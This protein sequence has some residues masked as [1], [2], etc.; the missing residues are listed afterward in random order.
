VRDAVRGA[1]PVDTAGGVDLGDL[2]RRGRVGDVQHVDTAEVG[3]DDE[4][5]LGGGVVVDDLCP[6][7]VEDARLVSTDQ[8]QPRCPGAGE[9]FGDGGV[10]RHLAARSRRGTRARE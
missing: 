10:R 6:A 5:S 9:R 3:V 4:Q 1:D 7:F 8:F 2:L